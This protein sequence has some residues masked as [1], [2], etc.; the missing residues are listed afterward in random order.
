MDAETQTTIDHGQ[1]QQ[2]SGSQLPVRSNT[3]ERGDE[4]AEV[5][6]DGETTHIGADIA[7]GKTLQEHGG[8]APGKKRDGQGKNGQATCTSGQVAR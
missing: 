4:H 8:G 6:S 2:A 7:E 5:L 1:N 3:K